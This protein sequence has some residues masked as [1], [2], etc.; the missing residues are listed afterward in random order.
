MYF[1]CHYCG[2]IPLQS[3]RNPRHCPIQKQEAVTSVF[4]MAETLFFFSRMEKQYLVIY[5]TLSF[6][7]KAILTNESVF[8]AQ[9][10][11]R[12][13]SFDLH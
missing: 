10:C 1:E 11:T 5:L 8:G 3:V 4:R 7:R 2:T 13:L 12:V 6:G 9:K